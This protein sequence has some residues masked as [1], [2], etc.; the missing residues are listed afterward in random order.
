V[1]TT[2]TGDPLTV[3]PAYTFT[4]TVGESPGATLA[5]PPKFGVASIVE[6]TAGVIRV[7][8]GGDVS[9]TFAA[10]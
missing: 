4:V 8:V 9:V 7:T 3:D 1:E 2:A 10:V 5:T 6:P